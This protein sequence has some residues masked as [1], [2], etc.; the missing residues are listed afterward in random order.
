MEINKTHLSYIKS[1]DSCIVLS[2][3]FKLNLYTLNKTQAYTDWA[4]KKHFPS[5]W[6]L[7]NP[8][9]CEKSVLA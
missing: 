5:Y 7:Q 2:S 4:W 6:G 8:L 3:F 9:V 1:V